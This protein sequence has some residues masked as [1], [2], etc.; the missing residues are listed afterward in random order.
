MARHFNEGD[1]FILH[2]DHIGVDSSDQYARLFKR[3]MAAIPADKFLFIFCLVKESESPLETLI[4]H[5]RRYQLQELTRQMHSNLE[6][7]AFVISS[8]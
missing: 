3:L 8:P 2:S 1:W 7:H 4:H 6:I 5:C